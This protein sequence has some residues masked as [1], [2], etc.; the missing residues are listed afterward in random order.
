MN[1][2]KLLVLLVIMAI[3]S[4]SLLNAIAYGLVMNGTSP[5]KDLPVSVFISPTKFG[6]FAPIMPSNIA[7]T[8]S[9][10]L[11]MM[12]IDPLQY[13]VSSFDRI[14]M[15]VRFCAHDTVGKEVILS[16]NQYNNDFGVVD[17]GS[18]GISLVC[19][20]CPDGNGGTIINK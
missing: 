10:G 1:S 5:M 18:N 15:E 20:S 12:R 6:L 14:K 11:W 16:Y 8:Q 2:K 13:P 7:Y 4:V 3:M 19:F 9:N 17:F